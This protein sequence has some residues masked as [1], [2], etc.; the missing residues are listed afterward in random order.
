MEE[1]TIKYPSDKITV[2]WRPERCIHSAVCVNGLGQ[3][4]NPRVKKWV[5]VEAA[6]DHQIMAQI[7]KCPSKALQ[8]LLN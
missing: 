4:F 6:T 7:E 8:Y 1:K 5:N 2:L 3:V